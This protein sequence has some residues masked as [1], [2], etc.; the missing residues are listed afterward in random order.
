VRRKFSILVQTS[1]KCEHCWIWAK[2]ATATSHFQPSNHRTTMQDINT[3]ERFARQ[4]QI[5][6]N[7]GNAHCA[8]ENAD[9][10]FARQLE[11]QLNGG[12][13]HRL[14]EN[15]DDNSIT[16]T[17][18]LDD[19]GGSA[20]A[21]ALPCS[22][23]YH[24]P[25]ILS[26]IDTR[27]TCPLCMCD[28]GGVSLYCWYWN[29]VCHSDDFIRSLRPGH[30]NQ[31][32]LGHPAHPINPARS[33]TPEPFLMRYSNR[34]ENPQCIASIW[35]N[36]RNGGQCMHSKLPGQS[37]CGIHQTR[38]A[39]SKK[40][41]QPRTLKKPRK[42]KRRQS[43]SSVPLLK[44]RLRVSSP[45]DVSSARRRQKEQIMKNRVG[46]GAKEFDKSDKSKGL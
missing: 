8:Q 10:R 27:R 32:H 43:S 21:L 17:I 45:K 2:C 13:V 40:P 29:N 3:D 39:I 31:Y 5:Q 6:L 15:A 18:C 14:Q 46:V 22:H 37:Y 20:S 34:E 7:Y 30:D 23:T 19:V 1:T 36:G 41:K 4:L 9:E 38:R 16:C 33:H 26:W 28:I 25:C 35:S 44:K 12:T 24:R 11:G 42:P